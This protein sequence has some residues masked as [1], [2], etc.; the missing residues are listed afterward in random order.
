AALGKGRD[1]DERDA[2]SITEKVEWLHVARVIITAAF[3][4]RDDEGCVFGKLGMCLKSIED[5]FDERF[6][7]LE[8][9][10]CGMAIA[11]AI[12]LQIGHRRKLAMVQII[13]EI[14][15]VLDVRL[16]LCRIAHD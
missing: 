13:E 7:N 14:N 8:L 11:E 1:D 3:V 10:A 4:K 6:K 12:R 15:R 5:T 2:R 9:G 16:A